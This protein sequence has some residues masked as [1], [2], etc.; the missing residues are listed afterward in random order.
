MPT[1]DD[2][3]PEKR[4]KEKNQEY[5]GGCAVYRVFPDVE[6]K[7]IESVNVSLTFEDAMRLS[8]ALQAAILQLN[9]YNR[10]SKSG[11]A[12]GINIGLMVKTKRVSVMQTTLRRR[13]QKM[14]DTTLDDV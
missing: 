6:E 2:D 14:D 5:H 10:S 3:K 8:V 1:N 13:K 11:K 9:R 7:G 4:I 12:T